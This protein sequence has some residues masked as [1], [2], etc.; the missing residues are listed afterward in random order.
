[1][2]FTI[3]S[4]AHAFPDRLQKAV[5]AL[6][7]LPLQGIRR[8]AR[9]WMRPFASSMH[10]A[11]PWLRLL[12]EAIRG[13]AEELTSL[14]PLPGLLVESTPLDL[15]E[16]MDEAE[17][18]TALVVAHPPWISNEFVMDMAAEDPRFAPVVNFPPSVN[19]P[20]KAL[21]KF[22]KAGARALK[23]HPA[24][25]GEGPESPHYRS[26]L[27]VADE[28]GLPVILHTGCVHSFL[29]YKDPAKGH[30]E[31]FIDWFREHQQLRFVLAHMNQH[32]P[33]GAMDLAEKYPNLLLETSWQPA[34]VIGEAVRRVGARRVLFGSDWP[35]VGDNMRV[36]I[37]RIRDCVETGM[38]TEAEAALI[39]GENA[40]EIFKI[41]PVHAS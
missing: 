3:D 40:A 24:A 22:F 11:R 38:F 39:L 28:L 7:A 20:G 16:A 14:A 1:M 18:E 15:A 12:P 17:V 41:E 31:L 25:D 34:E 33:Q 23:I 29:L 8:S 37:D 6:G 10:R 4:H 21:R 36:G 2:P 32:E 13:P 19:E 26:L 9:A 35:F 27:R 30:A 5:P